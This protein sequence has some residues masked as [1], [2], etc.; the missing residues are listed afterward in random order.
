MKKIFLCGLTLFG[1]LAVSRSQ[2]NDTT[3]SCSFK[4][5]KALE[6]V[7]A[8]IKGKEGKDKIIWRFFYKKFDYNY[9]TPHLRLCHLSLLGM[10]V[11]MT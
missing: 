2:S 3:S 9:L 7:T 6:G 4:G 5:S 1:L 11:V 10:I 8:F